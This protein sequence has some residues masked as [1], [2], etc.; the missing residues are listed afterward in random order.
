MKGSD[1]VAGRNEEATE[2]GIDFFVSDSNGSAATERGT[3]RGRGKR[4]KED[5]DGDRGVLSEDSH[6][7][8]ISETFFG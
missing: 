7:K 6:G 3:G 1:R 2:W 4:R 5:E 8:Y